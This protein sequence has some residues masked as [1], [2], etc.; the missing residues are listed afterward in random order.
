MAKRDPRQQLIDMHTYCRPAG[1]IAEQQFINRYLAPLPGLQRDAYGNWYAR[2][3]D[4]P[5]VWSCHTDTVHR[6]SGRQ[7]VHVDAD[8]FLALPIDS[9]SNCLGADDTIGVWICREL[10]LRRVPG[11]YLFHYGEERGGIGS[12]SL[13]RSD[14]ARLDGIQFAVAFDR[15]GYGDVITHQ[16]FGRTCSDAFAR[17]L[18]SAIAVVD[19]VLAYAPTEGV[20]TDTAEYAD[21]IPEC[22]NLSVGYH[23]QHGVNECAYLPFAAQLL[24][25]VAALDVSS[26][27][28][29]RDPHVADVDDRWGQSLVDIDWRNWS[30]SSKT[31][32]AGDDRTTDRA[33]TLR[34]DDDTCRD[35]GQPLLIAEMDRGTLCCECE[36]DRALAAANRSIYLDSVYADVQLELRA[37]LDKKG[38]L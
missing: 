3:G 11:L 6:L 34:W 24:E 28:C 30:P 29:E 33:I 19:P 18:A 23:R 22:S 2:I 32:K 16:A 4:A 7:R 35:C 10:L 37:R 38:M 1:S 9:H 5:I 26:L 15:A 36:S 31:G 14:A 20:Y 8:D 12:S 13:A 25:A 21:I 27:V 17:S